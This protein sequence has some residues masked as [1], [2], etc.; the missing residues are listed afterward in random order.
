MFVFTI[1]SNYC[2]L[3]V[4]VSQVEKEKIIKLGVKVYCFIFN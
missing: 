4:F 2:H 3:Y 1:E